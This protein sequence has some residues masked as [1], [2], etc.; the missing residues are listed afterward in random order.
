MRDFLRF[1]F[2]RDALIIYGVYAVMFGILAALIV[3]YWP[4]S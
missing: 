2:G 1:F 3:L 4:P